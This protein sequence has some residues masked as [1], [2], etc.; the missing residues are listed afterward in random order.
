MAPPP[1]Y[2]TGHSVSK[3]V[4]LG[5]NQHPKVHNFPLLCALF[6][7]N[8]PLSNP[9][10]TN[11]DNLTNIDKMDQLGPIGLFAAPITVVTSRRHGRAW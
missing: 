8:F 11:I 2:A 3:F 4:D 1:G 5:E 6:G 10:L 9:L 7:A